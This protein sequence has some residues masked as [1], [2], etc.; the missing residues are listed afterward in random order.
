[1]ADKLF[2]AYVSGNEQAGKYLD[3]YE[4]KFGPFDGHTAE[5]FAELWKIYLSY[6]KTR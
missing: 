2:W 3:T 6:K 4:S 5:E 1:M